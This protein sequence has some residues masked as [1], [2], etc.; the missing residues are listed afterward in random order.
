MPSIPE[1]EKTVQFEEMGAPID[2]SACAWPSKRRSSAVLDAMAD[3]KRWSIPIPGMLRTSRDEEQ[4][5][6]CAIFW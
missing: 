6:L 1:T 2:G 5:A 3:K 4:S